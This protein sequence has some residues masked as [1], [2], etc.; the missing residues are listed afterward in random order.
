MS[1]VDHFGNPV[2]QKPVDPQAPPETVTPPEHHQEPAAFAEAPVEPPE[3]E[4]SER[5][6]E[7]FPESRLP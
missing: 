5:Q 1:V 2:V 4:V 6:S 3:A 7:D